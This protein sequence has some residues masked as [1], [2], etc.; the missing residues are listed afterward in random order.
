[1]CVYEKQHVHT[2]Q[3]FTVPVLVFEGSA[4]SSEPTLVWSPDTAIA[5]EGRT[6]RIKVSTTQPWVSGGRRRLEGG[7]M[8]VL[9]ILSLPAK[10]G[11][12]NIKSPSTPTVQVSTESAS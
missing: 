10:K 8:S 12:I 6:T 3:Y 7:V 9:T 5:L 4:M 2:S 11:T 1:M